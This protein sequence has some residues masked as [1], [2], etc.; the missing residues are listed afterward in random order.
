VCST[1]TELVLL[2]SQADGARSGTARHGVGR[3][4]LSEFR[5]A[6]ILG[7]LVQIEPWRARK[8]PAARESDA[9]SEDAQRIQSAPTY[10]DG[11]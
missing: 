2:P 3:L 10:N 1:D 6:F 8:E 5:E 9:N 11:D 7:E 4:P